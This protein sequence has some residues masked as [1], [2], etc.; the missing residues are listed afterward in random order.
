METTPKVR[1]PRT[2]YRPKDTP[3]VSVS[4]TRLGKDILRA[5]AARLSCS[6]SDVVETLLREHGGRVRG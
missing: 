3:A 4:L 6:M 2:L 1:G 5:A